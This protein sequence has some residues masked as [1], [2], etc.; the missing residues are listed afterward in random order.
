[1]NDLKRKNAWFFCLLFILHTSTHCIIPRSA[2]PMQEVSAAHMYDEDS[3]RNQISHYIEQVR[4]HIAHQSASD[5]QIEELVDKLKSP[6][7][8]QL[9]E[10]ED[11]YEYLV[12]MHDRMMQINSKDTVIEEL[13]CALIM[14]LV[15]PLDIHLRKMA[16]AILDKVDRAL[17]YWHDQ[18]QSPIFYFFH[19]S[20]FKITSGLPQQQE[21]EEK[22]LLLRG[23]QKSMY[24][25]LGKWTITIQQFNRAAKPE[26]LYRWFIQLLATPYALL[27]GETLEIKEL[28]TYERTVPLVRDIISKVSRYMHKVDLYVDTAGKPNHFERNWLRYVTAGVALGVAGLYAQR[29]KQEIP[30]VY[31]NFRNTLYST[32]IQIPRDALC[33]AFPFL[34]PLFGKQLPADTKEPASNTQQNAPDAQTQPAQPSLRDRAARVGESFAE[35][36]QNMQGDPNNPTHNPTP[37]Q[38]RQYYTETVQDYFTSRKSHQINDEL[39]TQERINERSQAL[40]RGFIMRLVN[41]CFSNDMRNAGYIHKVDVLVNGISLLSMAIQILNLGGE[42]AKNDMQNILQPAVAAFLNATAEES[43]TLINQVRNIL[44]QNQVTFAMTTCLPIGAA[45]FTTGYMMKKL[46][47]WW[48]YKDYGVI[49]HTLISIAHLLNLYEDVHP[50]KMSVDHYGE[51][52]YLGHK[53]KKEKRKVPHSLRHT[54]VADIERLEGKMSA[55]KKLY[56][57]DL[58]YKTYPFLYY[59][60]A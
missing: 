35:I 37:E 26:E 14:Q 50:D 58:M 53:L 49:R 45:L 23:I 57:I 1:M 47:R 8:L 41:E 6:R 59:R 40:D 31:T 30:R 48:I 46:Y 4:T 17:A 42:N 21:I 22:L 39:I 36:I 24:Q 55:Q 27:H 54:F 19:K 32:F 25:L 52:L 20:P 43:E 13:R 56:V 11:L 38:L 7:A 2:Q 15:V 5:M 16:F 9:L 28:G 33:D 12:T 60:N 3:F 44:R 29:Y 34:N 51:L 10:I 18:Q